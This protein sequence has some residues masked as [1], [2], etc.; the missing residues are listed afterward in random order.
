M[1]IDEGTLKTPIP[2]CRIYWS[3]LFRVVNQFLGSQSGQKQSVKL[4]LNMVYNTT[5]PPPPPHSHR[6][7]VYTVHLVWEGGRSERREMGNSTQY[8]YFVH[9]DNNSQAGSKISTMGEC[10]SSL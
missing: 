1:I 5:Q 4:L 7:S 9:G 10:I 8:S 3:F 6:L 2:K